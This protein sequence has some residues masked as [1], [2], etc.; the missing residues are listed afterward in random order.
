M[1]KDLRTS[2][3][4]YY[5]KNTYNASGVNTQSEVRDNSNFFIKLPFAEVFDFMS[6][7]S[8]TTETVQV[9]LFG[10]RLADTAMKDVTYIVTTPT[11]ICFEDALLK[12]STVKPDGRSHIEITSASI[13]QIIAG[14]AR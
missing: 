9:E 7:I 8:T 1:S 12:V 4:F 14:A 11:G 5:H 3:Q 2:V 10:D 6:G 13:E